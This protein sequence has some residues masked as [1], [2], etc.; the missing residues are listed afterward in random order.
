M[1]KAQYELRSINS[2]CARMLNITENGDDI[3]TRRLEKNV[4][5]VSKHNGGTWN[6]Q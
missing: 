6:R 4:V 5:V 2:I 3:A 1:L